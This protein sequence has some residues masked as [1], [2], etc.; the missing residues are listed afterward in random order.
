MNKVIE[1]VVVW[2][3][4]ILSIFFACIE[5]NIVYKKR[6]KLLFIFITFIILFFTFRSIGLDLPV[7]NEW[8]NEININNFSYY[9]K[10]FTQYKLEPFF[11]IEIFLLKNI[12]LGFKSFLFINIALPLSIIYKIIVNNTENILLFFSIFLLVNIFYFDV[13]R[14]FFASVVFFFA[15]MQKQ[16]I[17]AIFLCLSN[18]L[19]HYSSIVAS[20]AYLFIGKKISAKNILKI[21]FFTM[22]A[23]LLMVRLF[24]NDL[25]LASFIGKKF[26]YYLK[27]DTVYYTFLSKSHV[28]L[29]YMMKSYLFVFSIWFIVKNYKNYL[30]YYNEKEMI[31]YNSI[32]IGILIMGTFICV[33]ALTLGV[34]IFSLFSLGIFFLIGRMIETSK[35]N[36]MSSYGLICTLLIFYNVINTLYYVGVFNKDSL[37]YI[38][39]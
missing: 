11:I 23:T 29:F 12:G 32:I 9:L 17:K 15:L 14:A 3:I 7:Y 20:A 31:L 33:N 37:F 24:N 28:I 25:F 10:H 22:V 36:A 1:I 6:K 30:K 18:Y 27:A 19:I 2:L 34:R 13:I 38:G 21:F 39:F 35:K 4:L 8:F 5:H 26:L 16:K